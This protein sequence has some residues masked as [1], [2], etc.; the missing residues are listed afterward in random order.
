MRTLTGVSITFNTHGDE[1]ADS[2]IVHVFIKNRSNTSSTP[3][4]HP[5]FIA[6][7][8]DEKRYEPDG[9]LLDLV[10]TPYLAFGIGLGAGQSFV[11]GSS[12]TFDLSLGAF[13]I[14]ADEIVLPAVSVHIVT[15]GDDQWTFDYLVTWRPLQMR[16]VP[17]AAS[18]C[19]LCGT[20]SPASP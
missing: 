19:L 13:D 2:T 11:A 18:R 14:N 8:L 7:W 15:D 12:L 1:K 9:D 20:A 5:D 6:N 10:G 4:S 16:V 17:L 3:E